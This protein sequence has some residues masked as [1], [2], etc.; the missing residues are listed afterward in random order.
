MR[1]SKQASQIEENKWR[2]RFH[3][4]SFNLRSLSKQ[5]LLLLRQYQCPIILSLSPISPVKAFIGRIS[6]YIDFSVGIWY[7]L[8]SQSFIFSSSII[9]IQT[10]VQNKQKMINFNDRS[11]NCRYRNG[12]FVNLE[13]IG[14]GRQTASMCEKIYPY[15]QLVRGRS[16]SCSSQ[17]WQ[18]LWR[19]ST[20]S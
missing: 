3:L 17:P 11:V 15:K 19:L 6:Q 7:W 2:K 18:S 20:R 14:G 13:Y 12:E 5:C 1:V 8:F 10:N 4:P 9:M 16:T